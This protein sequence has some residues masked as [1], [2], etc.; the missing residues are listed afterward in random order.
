MEDFDYRR[1]VPAVVKE[2]SK[3]L[4]LN[5]PTILGKPLGAV[6]SGAEVK[7]RDVIHSLANPYSPTGGLSIL[8]GNLAPE[9]AAIKG[10][11]VAPEM[12]VHRGPA[13]VFDSEEEAVEAM[14]E[15]NQAGD[16]IVI[17]YEGLGAGARDADQPLS[18]WNGNG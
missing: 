4:N 15:E 1:G 7:N 11:G 6:V 10:I 9:G 12:M 14:S 3:F 5:T 2:I 18:L 16:V 8:F 13:R 17:R